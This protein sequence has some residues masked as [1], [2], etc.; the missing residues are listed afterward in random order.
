MKRL[1]GLV[2]RGLQST[3]KYTLAPNVR[4]VRVSGRRVVITEHN[5]IDAEGHV[6]GPKYAPYD[7][8]MLVPRTVYVSR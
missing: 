5:P 6:T 3:A 4:L 1:P 7:R 8:R 2:M